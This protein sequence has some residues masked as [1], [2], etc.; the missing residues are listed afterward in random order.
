MKAFLSVPDAQVVAVC[1][2]DS[3]RL[4]NAR[5]AVEDTTPRAAPRG[6]SRAAPCSATFARCS[7][8]R[9]SMR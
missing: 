9:T 8:A 1:D 3:W 4:E 5:K 2:V 6:R 7:P